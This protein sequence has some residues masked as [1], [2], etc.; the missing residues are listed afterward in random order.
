MQR[1]C[2]YLN[3]FIMW[4]YC[5]SPLL[6][7]IYKTLCKKHSCVSKLFIAWISCML[8]NC[9]DKSWLAWCLQKIDGWK[10]AVE[11]KP[12]PAGIP[13]S[14]GPQ[15]V[16]QDQRPPLFCFALRNSLVSCY[17]AGW[18][19]SSTGWDRSHNGGGRRSS[20]IRAVGAL[21]GRS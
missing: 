12:T 10:K 15:Q 3:I 8:V 20:S 18:E 11:A 5:E 19:H 21:P 17:S 16:Q 13:A 4:I 6:L 7:S 1:N 9:L 2:H 14:K